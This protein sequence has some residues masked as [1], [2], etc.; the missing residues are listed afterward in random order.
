MAGHPVDWCHMSTEVFHFTSHSTDCSK[1]YS[2]VSCQKGPTRH[3]YAWQ[4]GPFWQNTLVFKLTTKKPSKLC[5][6]CHLCWESTAM[7]FPA[8]RA[9]NAESW[10]MSWWHDRHPSVSYCILL[11]NICHRWKIPFLVNSLRL[12][13]TY[14]HHW[15]ESSLIQ[16][17]T[18]H[19]FDKKPLPEA[20]LT[21]CQFD[22]LE[23]N[24]VK[25]KSKYQ[26]STLRAVRLSRTGKNVENGSLDRLFYNATCRKGQ[27]KNR[28]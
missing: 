21:Y 23:Q 1:A 12:N 10:S 27:V 4:I 19:F 20:M 26:G 8:Q 11:L 2:M 5:I 15:M 7:G 17:M 9:S 24:E 6:T 22:A 13:G 28:R 14:L 3:A 25:F 18:C 16:I